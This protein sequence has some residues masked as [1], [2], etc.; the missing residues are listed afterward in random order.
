[1]LK[2]C[3]HCNQSME[4][5]FLQWRKFAKQDHFKACPICGK[6]LEFRMYPEEIAVR[7]LS[8]VLVIYGFYWAKERGGGWVP[9]LA[10][11][12]AVIVASFF[13]VKFRLKDQQRF[14]KG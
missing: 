2:D 12:I 11:V 9:M 3:P 14:R 8:V 10:T 13:L 5:K 1:M 6:G 7:V 4:G